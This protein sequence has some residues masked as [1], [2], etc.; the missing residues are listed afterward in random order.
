MYS[1]TSI[2]CA[3]IKKQFAEKVEFSLP[4]FFLMQKF[5]NLSTKQLL[6]SSQRMTSLLLQNVSH[7][8]PFVHKVARTWFGS[9]KFHSMIQF[10]ATKAR[11]RP[12]HCTCEVHV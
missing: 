6:S 7:F 5:Y 4:F 8:I 11:F 12:Q 3:R 2:E 1:Q 9:L 10:E